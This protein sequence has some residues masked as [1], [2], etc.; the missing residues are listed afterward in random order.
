MLEVVMEKIEVSTTE[1][2][3]IDSIAPGLIGLRILFVNVFAVTTASGWTLIDAGLRGSAGRIKRWAQ[4]HFGD[5][6][7]NA[8][9]LTHGHFDHVGAIDELIESWDVPVYVHSEELG[10][11]TGAMSY[12]P[13]DPSVGGGMMARMASLYP[14]APIDLGA[15]VR[16]LPMDG[17]IPPM[18]GWRWVHTPGHSAG[19]VALFRDDDRALIVG[20]AFCTTKQESFF[21]AM[22]QTPEL[23]GPPAYFTTD[24]DAARDSVERLAAL[25][26]AFIAPGHGKPM[27]GEQ[28][29]QSL[30]ELSQRF[31][32]VARPDD[33]QYVRQPVRR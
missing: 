25:R 13:P 6:A 12:P 24:W 14:R 32:E 4:E 29:L 21:A 7:P 3:P 27:A 2:V 31:D 23:H 9:V 18:P 11:V 22:A 5:T 26:P 17:T 16:E 15:R 20:D 28:A 8:V 30:I 33:G 1:I 19:H 10:Y